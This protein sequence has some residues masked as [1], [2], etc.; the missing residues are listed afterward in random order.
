[1][2]YSQ[3]IGIGAVALLIVACFLPWA[4]YPDLQKDFTGFYSEKN[5]YG[6]PGRVFMVLAVPALGCF[7]IPRVW[8]KRWNLFTAGLIAAYAIKSFILFSGCYSG[9][10]PQKKEG[11]WLMLF[12]SVVVL[13]MAVFPEMKLKKMKQE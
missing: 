12:A 5:I 2:K 9:T 3:W 7:L 8:A 4:W 13:V 6:K 10:C 11:L 1:M